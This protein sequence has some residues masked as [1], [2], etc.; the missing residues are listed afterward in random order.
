MKLIVD[1]MYEGGVSKMYWSVSDTAEYGGY[2]RGPRV[3]NAETKKEMRRILD[4]IRDGRFAREL[5]EEFDSGQTNF[6]R[7]RE[8][9]AGHSIEQTGA[10]LRPM[11]SWL[12]GAES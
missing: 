1:L 6:K 8:E 7:Y 10:K 9:L 3:V 2:S 5:V 12:K 11:M 4:E